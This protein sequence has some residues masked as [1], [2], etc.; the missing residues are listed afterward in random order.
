MNLLCF[1]IYIF[2][3]CLVFNLLLAKIKEKKTCV[4]YAC[5][6]QITFTFTDNWMCES[7]LSWMESY[8]AV[9]RVQCVMFI[10]MTKTA[11]I[12]TPSVETPQTETV[13]IISDTVTYTV[14]T[15]FT[16]THPSIHLS[17]H[18]SLP[19][20]PFLTLSPI[21]QSPPWSLAA[22]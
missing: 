8:T 13:L 5:L 7:V 3:F 21:P 12:Y 14:Y 6:Q 16:T 2:R 1:I 4:F 9:Q 10:T 15:V 19:C 18:S 17:M 20:G 11:D 22:F